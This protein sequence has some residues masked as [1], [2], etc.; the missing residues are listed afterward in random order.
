MAQKIVG[1]IV[2]ILLLFV[3]NTIFVA[4]VPSLASVEKS[5]VNTTAD[6]GAKL[7][8]QATSVGMSAPARVSIGG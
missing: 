7:R 6:W 8:G 4:L 2:A 3:A 1:F 5:Y